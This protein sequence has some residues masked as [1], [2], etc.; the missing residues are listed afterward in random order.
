[1]LIL[2]CDRIQVTEFKLKCDKIL[3]ELFYTCWGKDVG[4]EMDEDTVNRLWAGL[5]K[6]IEL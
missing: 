5:Y 6:S 1:M 2:L 4:S 3:L